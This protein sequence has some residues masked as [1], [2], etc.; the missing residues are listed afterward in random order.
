MLG[1]W[2][3]FSD[4][5]YATHKKHLL[6]SPTTNSSSPTS[7]DDLIR[8]AVRT[9]PTVLYLHGTTGTR[10]VPLRVQQ[11]QAFA[12]RL[13]ANVLAP[14]YRGFADSTG[15]PSEAGLT[16]DAR[17]AWDWLRAHGAS[18]DN[19][20]VVGTSLGTG[21][22]VQFASAL[23]EEVAQAEA[24]ALAV[25]SHVGSRD[26]RF[27][28]KNG[29]WIRESAVVRERPRG[30]V[31]FSP[32]S[33]LETLIDTYYILGL[34]PLFAPLRTFPYLLSES[35]SPHRRPPTRH[36][37]ENNGTEPV[38][39]CGKTDLVKGLIVNRFDSLA[40]VVVRIVFSM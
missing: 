24:K 34:M 32:F 14:D 38:C 40:K 8:A 3:T 13:R 23:E 27:G 31:L 22:A 6:N 7:R 39:A 26:M 20:L 2:F 4:P 36:T 5:F 1:A 25:E 11:Y 19:V 28:G 9:R 37:S 10:V 30:V 35:P 33:K 18:P 29:S 12:A 17:A 15:T 16:L 21:V